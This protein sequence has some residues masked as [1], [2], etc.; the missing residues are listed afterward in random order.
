MLP[1]GLWLLFGLQGCEGRVYQGHAVGSAWDIGLGSH[2][3]QFL[4]Y[5]PRES[6]RTS[7]IELPSSMEISSTL[8]SFTAAP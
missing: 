1:T 4:A 5:C 7:P 2:P 8:E 6:P 3:A